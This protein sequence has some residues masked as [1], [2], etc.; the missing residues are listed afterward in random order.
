M[1]KGNVS[2]NGY[3]YEGGELCGSEIRIKC[4]IRHEKDGSYDV[5]FSF[6]DAISNELIDI[7]CSRNQLNPKKL[8]RI[9][10]EKGGVNNDMFAMMRHYQQR[11]SEYLSIRKSPFTCYDTGNEVDLAGNSVPKQIAKV[12]EIMREHEFAGWDNR[13]GE[14][15]F[16]GDKIYSTKGVIES[17]YCGSLELEAVGDLEEYKKMI[18]KYVIGNVPLEVIMAVAVSAT[19]LGYMNFKYAE[20]IYNPVVHIYNT[21]S[22][23]K[24][25]AGELVVSIGSCPRKTIGSSTFLT[26]NGTQ[27]ALI[28][29]IGMNQGYPVTIDEFSLANKKKI[30]EFIYAIAEG[31]DKERL[32]TQGMTLQKTLS[33]MTTI[34]TTG[35]ES[36]FVKCNGN[37]GLRARMIEF[38][39]ITWTRSAEEA[40]E[41]KRIIRKNYGFIVPLVAQELLNDKTDIWYSSMQKWLQRFIEEAKEKNICVGITERVAK[42]LSLF[43]VSSEILAKVMNMS[44]SHEKIYSFLLEQVIDPIAKEVNLGKR[45][46][47]YIRNYYAKNKSSFAYREAYGIGDYASASNIEGVMIRLKSDRSVGEE[48]YER[49]LA[50]SIEQMDIILEKGGF[51]DTKVCMRALKQM[52]LLM[53][54]GKKSERLDAF[55]SIND[56]KCRGY[57]ILFPAEKPYDY[58]EDDE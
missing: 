57:R 32:S 26:F 16:Y 25:T 44:F 53:T 28:K 52:G 29:K 55:F 48:K 31:N 10:Q 38:E 39:G 56:E 43:M 49:T 34:V 35:E 20:E 33:F 14:I 17:K 19:V 12:P 11:E 8:Q 36:M 15:I 58:Q 18:Y 5:V 46:Y 24:T 9:M 50:I 42:T 45:V 13:D 51:R 30:S 6:R 47:Q 41:I 23:G 3:Y 22:T 7:K 4:F 21:S 54:H 2:E 27:N 1:L 40:E 37:E